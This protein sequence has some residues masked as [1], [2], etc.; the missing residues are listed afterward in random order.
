MTP[1]C[2]SDP[3]P[4]GIERSATYIMQIGAGKKL[5]YSKND[6]RARKVREEKDFIQ[7]PRCGLDTRCGY[8]SRRTKIRR[9]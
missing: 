4:M 9:C 1:A 2:S 8:A 5:G 6:T 3:A 7:A